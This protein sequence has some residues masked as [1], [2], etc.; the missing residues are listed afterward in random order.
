MI[1]FEL[2]LIF[3]NMIEIEIFTR[4]VNEHTT[5]QIVT[6][7]RPLEKIS[8]K[9]KTRNNIIQKLANFQWDASAEIVWNSSI[10]LVYSTIEYCSQTWINSKHVWLK[11]ASLINVCGLSQIL[12]TTFTMA[13]HIR[14]HCTSHFWHQCSLG[15]IT[16]ENARKMA[17][18]TVCLAIYIA[19]SSICCSMTDL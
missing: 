10:A 12:S 14:Q 17:Q 4:E 15:Y 5:R 16:F 9:L 19:D 6:I 11:T 8:S 1:L 2:T 18:W 7:S 3:F 13:P